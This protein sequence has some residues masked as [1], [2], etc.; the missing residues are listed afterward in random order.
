MTFLENFRNGFIVYNFKTFNFS[1]I[2]QWTD[3]LKVNSGWRNEYLVIGIAVDDEDIE[4]FDRT[5]LIMNIK[6]S[7]KIP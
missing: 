5:F 7:K 4:E 6:D 1:Q 2:V 3:E